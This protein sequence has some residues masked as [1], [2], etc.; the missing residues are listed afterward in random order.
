M[1]RLVLLMLVACGGSSPKAAAPSN[2]GGV[3]TAAPIVTLKEL[4]NGDRACYVI[5]TTAAGEQS[6]EGDFELCAGGTRDA[7]SMI[8]KQITY[9][10]RKDKVL[11]AS[12]QGDVDCGKSD[13]V[14]LVVT[15]SAAP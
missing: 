9:T 15:I 1:H 2:T 12:C 10:T 13:E 14:D 7:T 11:A 6:L 5:V 3:P 8:G 4:Q